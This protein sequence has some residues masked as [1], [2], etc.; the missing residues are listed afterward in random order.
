[1]E[2]N[3]GALKSRHRPIKQ[4]FYELRTLVK[5]QWFDS[6]KI[7]TPDISNTNNFTYDEDKF[8]IPTSGYVI[9]LKN[10]MN[11][12]FHYLYFLGLLNSKTLEFY[13]KHRSPFIGGKYFRYDEP[14]L[15]Q[16]PIKLPQTNDE[17]KISVKIERYV[18]QL[19]QFN[20]Q[21]DKL[22]EKIERFPESYFSGEK[23]V[24]AAEECK[25]GK[26]KYST[27]SLALEPV[28]KAGEELYKLALTKEDCILFSSR[29]IAECVLEQLKRKTKVRIDEIHRLKVPF[30]KDV[31]RVMDEFSSDKKRI[32][33]IR[34]EV[35][36]LEREIDE[37]VYEL[38]E[39][40]AKD[41]EVIEEFLKKF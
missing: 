4:E 31:S 8:Y 2:E 36:K 15:D 21:L 9:V 16:L 34:K 14:H 32:D 39:L 25:L 41:R 23:L 17:K 10:G 19:L 11:D 20:K 26:N 5:S 33:E 12:K 13:F 40:D 30:E 24:E 18:N 7:M 38:Y 27:K 6:P 28:K 37:L 35:R 29:A 1:M 22:E 3:K